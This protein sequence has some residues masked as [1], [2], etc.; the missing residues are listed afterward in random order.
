M[1][2]AILA[3]AISTASMPSKAECSPSSLAACRNTNQLIWN[4]QFQ[5]AIWRFL[6]FRRAAFLGR[7]TFVADQIIEVLGG[8]PDPPQKI[9][10]LYRFTA[11]RAHS[12]DEKG[13]AVLDADGRIDALGILHT[14]CAHRH[15]ANDCFAHVTLNLFMRRP[16]AQQDVIASLSHWA[17]SEI[18]RA[19]TAAGM[20]AERWEGVQVEAVH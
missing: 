9:G 14:A 13:V 16:N 19:Y 4:A 11:C 17:K 7:R 10:A 20:P 2:G 1:I 8:P 18:A 3:V 6:G 12:C 5:P 15:P